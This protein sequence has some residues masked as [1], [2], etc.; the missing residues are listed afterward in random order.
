MAMAEPL[1]GDPD[2]YIVH[3]VLLDEVNF[4]SSFCS[5]SYEKAETARQMLAEVFGHD[6]VSVMRFGESDLE[7][8][9]EAIALWAA[10]PRI[11]H[12]ND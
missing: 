3:F 1:D 8:Y 12:Q 6:R 10:D 4:S 7:E 9:R 2:P 5:V 11:R